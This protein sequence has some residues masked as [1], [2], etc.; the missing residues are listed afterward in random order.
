[1]DRTVGTL[2][3]CITVRSP[4]LSVGRGI[5]DKLGAEEKFSRV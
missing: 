3:K 4:L 2:R 1:M 5:D